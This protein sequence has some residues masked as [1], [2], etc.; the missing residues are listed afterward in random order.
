M[1]SEY[2]NFCKS[3]PAAAHAMHTAALLLHTL[4]T[5]LLHTLSTLLLHTLST[6]LLHTLST[7]LLHT[8]STHPHCCYT[9]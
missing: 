2:I 9:R 7:L 3:I 6:L 5:L 8:L 1:K 4:C